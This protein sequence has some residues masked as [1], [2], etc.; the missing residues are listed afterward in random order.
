MAYPRRIRFE[1]VR[2]AAFGAIG[3]A[4][5]AIGGATAQPARLVRISNTGDQD[6]YI[7]FNGVI[8]HLRITTGSFFLI[9]VTANKVRDDGFFLDEGTV[10]YVRRVGAALTSGGVYIEVVYGG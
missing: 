10:F 8:D 3:A 7:S 5:N 6:V 4:Y 2:E 1:A 9:D